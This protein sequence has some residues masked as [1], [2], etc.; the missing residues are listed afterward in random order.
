[1]A[2]YAKNNDKKDMISDVDNIDPM[3]SEVMQRRNER[4]QRR[5]ESEWMRKKAIIFVCFVLLALIVVVSVAVL[6]KNAVKKGS[7]DKE[8]NTVMVVDGEDISRDEFTFFCSMVLQSDEFAEISSQNKDVAFLSGYVKDVATK[9]IEEFLCKVHN[10]SERGVALSEQ[11]ISK[12]TS[13]IENAAQNYKSKD[14]Y[15]YKYYGMD[16]EDYFNLSK[17]MSLVSKFVQMVYGEADLSKDNQ[18]D[19]YSANPEEFV[20]L[21]VEMIYMDVRGLDAD[22]VSYKKTNAETLLN[23]V[24]E[25][26]DICELSKEHSDKNNLFDIENHNGNNPLKLS[27][28]I[29]K[30]FSG[31]FSAVSEMSAGDVK[32]V[33]TENEICVVKCVGKSTF[34]DSFDSEKLT[35]YVKY[36]HASEY[37]KV[38]L[39]S[40]KYSAEI[41]QENFNDTDIGGYIETALGIYSQEK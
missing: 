39:S 3:G 13:D 7:S 41:N 28:E 25:G 22:S 12:I 40:G 5:I 36:L 11:E 10:A 14:E 31:L 1:M 19:I 18:S 24:N 33:E 29:G 26:Q 27:S 23:Y 8:K 16:Y 9:N 32:I 15:C 38:L 35:S 6:I 20:T 30:E 21:D 17:Q 34:E 4:I 2:D 37:F